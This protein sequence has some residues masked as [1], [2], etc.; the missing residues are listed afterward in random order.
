[1]AGSNQEIL[2]VPRTGLA[3]APGCQDRV[4]VRAGQPWWAEEEK[5]S[6]NAYLTE[7]EGQSYSISEK[8]YSL[9]DCLPRFLGHGPGWGDDQDTVST[10]EVTVEGGERQYSPLT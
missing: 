9:K 3:V 5:L 6:V 1:M 2:C 10:I 8:R 7:S 4:G